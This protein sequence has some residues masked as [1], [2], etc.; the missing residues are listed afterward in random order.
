MEQIVEFGG[1]L[2]SFLLWIRSRPITALLFAATVAVI[3]Y[4]FGFLRLYANQ[5]QPIWE[6]AW[7][8]FLPQYNQEHSKLIPPLVLFL[9]WYHRDQIRQAPRSGS[10]LGI[11]FIAWGVVC[12]VVAARAFQPR[13]A[14]FGFPFLV[15]GMVL[16]LWGREMA[17][18]LRF[19]IALLF[20]MIPLGAL[21]QTTFR[22]QFLIIGVV[23]VSKQPLRH[24]H[25]HHRHFHSSGA[26]RLG[27]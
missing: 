4:F 16:F 20:F 2:R 13:V 24:C 3:V 27:V 7:L 26:R 17:R 25:L 8:R 6:W 14:L 10:N 5:S 12:Y 19:P 11:L 23:K 1:A 22:L 15:Y 9:L 21:E 18:I